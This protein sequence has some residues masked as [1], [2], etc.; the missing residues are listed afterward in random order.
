MHR[1]IVRIND[2]TKMQLHASP[3]QFGLAIKAAALKLRRT[4]ASSMFK[5]DLDYTA[6]CDTGLLKLNRWEEIDIELSPS[7]KLTKLG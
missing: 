6:H 3:S 7:G 5:T 1:C 2:S 4:L